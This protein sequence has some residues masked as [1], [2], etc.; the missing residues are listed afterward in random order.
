MQKSLQVG[1]AGA[2]K[3]TDSP[4]DHIHLQ[5]HLRAPHPQVSAVS[6]IHSFIRSFIHLYI[7]KNPPI[8]KTEEEK[9]GGEG[10]GW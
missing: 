2:E 9:G 6:F 5:Q 8:L 10:G 1:K 3:Q 7:G 4:Q